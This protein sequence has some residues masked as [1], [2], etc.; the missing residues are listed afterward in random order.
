MKHMK[1]SLCEIMK[2]VIFALEPIAWTF[3]LRLIQMFY[4]VIV[5]IEKTY[6]Y[7]PND[8]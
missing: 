8:F 2:F 4:F 5:K 3:L 6:L 1:C 7:I